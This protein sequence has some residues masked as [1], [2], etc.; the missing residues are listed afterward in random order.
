MLPSGNK[1]IKK[2]VIV[3]GGTAGWFSA[4]ILTRALFKS[5]CKIELIESPDIPTIGVGEATIPSIVDTLRYLTIPLPEFIR[6]TQATFKL[7]IK[8]SDWHAKGEHYW[9]QF[10][11][12]GSKIDDRPFYQ[13]WLKY[14]LNG[15][16]YAYTDF[17]PSIAMAKHNKFYINDPNKPTNLSA[18][19]YAFHFDAG[20]V[21][22]YL[23]EFC[24][25]LGVQH[26]KANVESASLS[27]EGE[28]NHLLLTNGEKVE[29]DFF[30]DC[31]GQSALL[32][33][34]ALNVKYEN[35]QDYLPVDRAVAVQTP[36]MPLLMPYTESIAHEHGWRWRI[37]L[38]NRTG[39][40]YV[41]C[42]DYCNQQMAIKLLEEK[43]N[44]PFLTEPRLIGFTTGKREKF[45][46][47]N[48]LAIGLSAG[49]LEPLESTSINLVVKGMMD[50][51]N[52]LPDKTCQQATIDEYNRLMDIEYESIRDFLV[53]HYCKTSRTDS[54]FWRSW[55]ERNIPDSLRIKLA[56]FQEQGRLYYNDLDLFT[57]DSWYAVLEGMKVRPDSYD[58]LVDGSDFL[59][60]N[61]TLSKFID[62]LEKSVDLLLTHDQFIDKISV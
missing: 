9:H 3:G 32:I 35:W 36:K 57:A 42:S 17:S 56:L 60:I 44:A 23:N 4:A 40:G 6:E 31:T 24:V 14:M 18:S 46:Y 58:P 11:Y 28:I 27:N 38:Q 29:G 12:V 33:E 7:A 25:D 15:G 16:K 55:R 8:F 49:F 61:Q 50:F 37:P 51:V 2:F 22:K 13:H 54:D 21:A 43:V 52:N 53:L 19:T 59:K 34:K 5:D 1:R 10:G 39:N 45:W 62:D 48:C 47:K 26:T 41:F 30:I 20:L